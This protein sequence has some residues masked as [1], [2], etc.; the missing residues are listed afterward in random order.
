VSGRPG[1]TARRE[2]AAQAS[3]A[4]L[5]RRRDVE[6][7]NLAFLDD[8]PA[9]GLLPERHALNLDA[10]GVSGVSG[11]RKPLLTEMLDVLAAEAARRGIGR[12][13]IVNGDIVVTPAAIDRV[14]DIGGPAVAFSR[15][16]VGEGAPEALMLYGVDMFV[17]DLGFWQRER[18]RFRP[19]LLG[20]AVWDNV[21]ASLVVCRG[22]ALL[23][24]ERLILHERH[25]SATRNS[26]FEPYVH[27]LAARDRSYFTLWCN[28]IARAEALRARDGSVAEE[29][30]LQRAV[31]HTPGLGDRAMDAG[32]AAWWRVKRM[33][34]A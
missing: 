5:T 7:V 14:V 11:A 26:P 18:G 3:L 13:G 8:P 19:Y 1:E 24:R 4:A 10:P 25:P 31:F 21:Y 22:G 33:R 6:C 20:E 15:T 23:N 28:Y 9:A 32:R 12:I 29:Y 2:A 34:G 17:F 30:A 16:D 27:L